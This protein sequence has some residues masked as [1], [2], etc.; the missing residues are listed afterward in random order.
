VADPPHRPPALQDLRDAHPPQPSASSRLFER[1]GQ[2]DHWD[3]GAERVHDR[4]EP[5]MRDRQGR[6]FQHCP[7]RHEAVHHRRTGQALDLMLREHPAM[8]DQQ[9]Y[10][11]IL[12]SLRN[13]TKN[14]R[15]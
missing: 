6:P 14:R 4:V 2:A 15:S 7:L 9:I 5:A 8:R 12:G 11:Q 1:D 13:C 3:T 10:V